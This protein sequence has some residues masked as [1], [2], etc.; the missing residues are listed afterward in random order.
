MYIYIY[1]Y[2]RNQHT[3]SHSW[4]LFSSKA[5]A[6]IPLYYRKWFPIDHL[7]D[8]LDQ[9]PVGFQ[10]ETKSGDIESKSE[11]L[12]LPGYMHGLLRSHNI[13]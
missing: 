4:I 8:S 10:W 12:S 6:Q 5:T 1:I 2:T 13:R 7:P 3:P 11:S 9:I